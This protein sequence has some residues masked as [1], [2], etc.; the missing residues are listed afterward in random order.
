MII[1]PEYLMR[2]LMTHIVNATHGLVDTAGDQAVMS[3]IPEAQLRMSALVAIQIAT[4]QSVW[5]ADRKIT[6]RKPKVSH[7]IFEETP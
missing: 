3:T 6:I 2:D 5:P 7:S 1:L 4:G